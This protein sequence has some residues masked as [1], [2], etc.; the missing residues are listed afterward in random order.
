MPGV[1]VGI[2]IPFLNV[3]QNGNSGGGYDPSA[4]LYFDKLIVQP[5]SSFKNAINNF[6]IQLKADGNW[7]FDRLWIHATEYR[8]H[9]RVSLVN[10]SSTEITEVN[11]PGWLAGKGYFGD[12][13]SAYLNSNYKL[14]TDGINVTNNSLAHY[15]YIYNT[16]DAAEAS[17]ICGVYQT[18][19]AGTDTII[20]PYYTGG[21]FFGSAN[22]LGVENSAAIASARGLSAAVRTDSMLSKLFRNGSEIASNNFAAATNGNRDYYMLCFNINGSPTSFSGTNNKLAI[23]G[24]SSGAVDQATFFAAVDALAIALNFK[25]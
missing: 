17:S 23:S 24:L 3:Q 5:S 2:S 14:G 18:G 13:A 7:L 10:P 11:S 16:V 20:Q 12:G 1:G 19:G 9:A 6:V 25:P 4:Q 21:S 8:Q 15:A 22:N